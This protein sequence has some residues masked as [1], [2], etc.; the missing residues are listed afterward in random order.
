MAVNNA[1]TYFEKIIPLCKKNSATEYTFGNNSEQLFTLLH[2]FYHYFNANEDDFNEALSGITYERGCGN[3]ID[4]LF[5]DNSDEN[6]VIDVIHVSFT[7]NVDFDIDNVLNVFCMMQETI[8]N[9]NRKKYPTDVKIFNRREEIIK[10]SEEGHSLSRYCFKFVTNQTPSDEEKQV[11]NDE[12]EKLEPILGIRYSATF[13]II[14]GDEVV[15]EI[16]DIESPKEY[17]EKGDLVL[18][19][20]DAA[21]FYG[22]E[23]SF[24]TII[25]A[26]SLKEIFKKYSKQGL[27][28][29]NLRY[30]VKSI[31]IDDPIRETIVSFG[32][33]F[34]YYNNGL[35]IVCDNYLIEGN[36]LSLCNFS[37]VNGAQ[38]TTLIGSTPFDKD[39]FI[40]CK[41]IKNKYY[42]QSQKTEFISSIAEASNAQKQIKAKDLIAN[43]I[44]Q[45]L[46][47]SQ[48]AS[49]GVFVQ[50]KRGDKI[51]KQVYKEGWQNT[52]NSEIAQLL[53]SM[54]Y[55]HPGIARNNVSKM[56]DDQQTYDTIF[57]ID[58]DTDFIVD[59][60]HLRSYY[61]AWSKKVMKSIPSDENKIPLVKNGM[62]FM[63]AIFGAILKFFYNEKLYPLLVECGLDVERRKF[64]LAQPDINHR[65]FRSRDVY[66]TEQVFKLSEIL[67]KRYY[68]P[69]YLARK[70]DE[71]KNDYS[72]FTKTDSNFANYVFRDIFRDCENGI[73]ASISYFLKTSFYELDEKEK[74]KAEKYFV[75]SYNPGFEKELR[76][77]RTSKTKSLK[78]RISDVMTDREITYITINKPAEPMDLYKIQ[79]FSE[80]RITKFGSEIVQIVN[81]YRNI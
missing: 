5:L 72:N 61:K 32:D 33:R 81:K 27:F 56:L 73:P 12:I 44:E 79:G 34:W 30:Y 36:V 17:V 55:L 41:I 65:F 22:D 2:V 7:I 31:K 54:L 52:T 63:F 58:Y 13:K 14:Y 35:I 28:A 45:R 29:M 39:F 40:T 20:A 42:E 46:L 75:T 80:K 26:S 78:I 25:S 76:E 37:I 6:E 43:R 70:G 9:I 24:L 69:A 11:F 18:K 62:M 59:L 4:G 8:L 21:P 38:T 57:K 64:L 3:V 68:G 15:G 67:Y 60:L 23:K 49:A 48:M 74:V 16:D 1:W 51:N 77:Y 53:Y 19:D 50:V 47:K 71:L 66:M 10:D